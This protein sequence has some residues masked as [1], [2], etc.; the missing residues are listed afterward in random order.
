MRARL[1][2]WLERPLDVPCPVL[3][4]IFATKLVRD[5]A[6]RPLDVHGHISA[7][8]ANALYRTVREIRP[9]IALEIGM[10]F[11][12]SSLAI[13]QALSDIGEGGRLISVDPNQSALWRNIGVRNIERAGLAAQ[14]QLI[15]RRDYT[16][17]PELLRK[18]TTVQ[19]AYIDG[20]H[21][22]DYVL[23]DFFYIDKMLDA[24]GVVAFN[25]C[26]LGGVD[27]A[28]RFVRSHRR[29][30]PYDAGLRRSY[31]GRDVRST[32]ARIAT[33]RSK[34]DRYFRKEEAW[35]PEWDFY[36]RF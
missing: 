12:T 11:G 7:A 8:H 34:S 28:M 19:F 10:A 20:W 21:T 15:E 31:L 24:G 6:G 26:A 18:R 17:L 3:D 14:H 9:P 25:D 36:A 16:A 27:R 23:L 5:A 29:Y 33:R 13:A 30:E 2:N 32:L 35:E 1:R 4:E 22:F